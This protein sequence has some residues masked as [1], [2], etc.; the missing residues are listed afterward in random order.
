MVKEEEVE[1]PVQVDEKQERMV[2]GKVQ[3]DQEN[4]TKV[5]PVLSPVP[6]PE[7]QSQY[8]NSVPVPSIPKLNQS[9]GMG[10]VQRVQFLG[11]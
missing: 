4:R 5:N 8:G 7:P 1:S 3:V 6:S 2:D 11:G 10:R 9:Q